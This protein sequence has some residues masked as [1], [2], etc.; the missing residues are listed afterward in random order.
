MANGQGNADGEDPS[1]AAPA[2]SGDGQAESANQTRRAKRGDDGAKSGGD[3]KDRD[4]K[5]GDEDEGEDGD[6]DGD[7]DGDGDDEKPKT[8]GL[9][10]RPILLICAA[11]ALVLAIIFGVA[12]WLHSRHF[13]TTDDA[14]V[15][16]HIV[17]L[18]PQVA[19]RV[20]RVLVN[21]NQ[22]VGPNQPLVDIDSSDLLTRVAQAQ[23]Q[24]AQA[25]S[26]VDNARVQIAVNEAGYQQAL[27]DARSADAQAI[28]AARDLERY[29]TLQR[30]NASAVAQQQ[31]D[32]AEAQARQTAAQRDSAHKAAKA[33]AEQIVAS[34]TQV[35]SGEDQVRA[36][37]AELDEANINAGYSHIVAPVFGHV[38]QKSVAVGNYVQPGTQLLAIVP[39]NVWITANFKETQLALMRPGQPV[40]VKVDACPRLKI[41]GHVDSIQRGAGQAFGI[42]PP[43]NATGNYVKVVQRVPVKIVLDHPPA[44]CPLGPGMSVEPRVT[45][46]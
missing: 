29:L 10:Q 23:A 11:L 42:L 35:K 24:K 9:L 45:V 8:K 14:F 7:G 39:T 32:Q 1:D 12:F 22:L 19:G 20:T 27:A 3:G 17:R 43:E 15:D 30:L 26:Q 36:A 28:N 41:M 16:T 40:Q 21:D 13:E 31:M 18:A 46:R 5:D 4:A 6:E 25:Q 34:R 2:K 33:R 38:A 37:Q 44:D